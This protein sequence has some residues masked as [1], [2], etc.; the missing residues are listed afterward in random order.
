MPLI[1]LK[2]ETKSRIDNIIQQKI[3]INIDNATDEDKIE[4]I[5][6][7]AHSK[8]NKFGITYDSFI[9]DL[10]VYSKEYLNTKNNKIIK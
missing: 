6:S 4:F 5:K 7:M 9:S 8:N 2:E 1:R 10:L 3:R